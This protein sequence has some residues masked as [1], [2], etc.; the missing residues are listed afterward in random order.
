M[1][2]LLTL[3]AALFVGVLAAAVPARKGAFTV[4][5]PDGSTLRLERHGDEFFNW[6]TLAG[7]TQ[8]VRLSADG[9]WRS[10]VIDASE[11]ARGLQRRAEA[12]RLRVSARAT[13]NDNQMTHGERHIPVLLLEFTDVHFTIADPASRFNALLNQRGYSSDGATGSVQDYYWENSE[14]QFKPVFDVYGPVELPHEMKYYGETVYD[15]NGKKVSS[16]I[17]PE[18]P[19]YDGCVKLDDVIDFSRY[20]YDNDGKVDM[21]LYYYAGYNTAEGGSPDAIWPHQWHLSYSSDPDARNARFDGKQV[22]RY[23]CTSELKGSE[24]ERMCGIG[25]TCHE[26]GHSLGLPDFYDTDDEENGTCSALFDFSTMCGGSYNNDG[27]TPPWFGAEERII[28]GWMSR[29]DVRDFSEGSL[30]IGPVQDGTAYK[31]ESGVEGEYFIYECRNGEGWDAPIPKGLLV[32]HADKSKGRT[33]GGRTPYHLWNYTNN[34]NAYGDHPCFYVVPA[35]DPSNL[36]YKGKMESCVFPGTAGVRTFIPEDWDGNNLTGLILSGINYSGGLVQLSVSFDQA[37]QLIGRVTDLIGNPL[38]DVYVK[39]SAPAGSTAAPRVLR[40]EFRSIEYEAVTDE[41]GDFILALGGFEHSTGHLTLSKQGYKTAG[42]D[43]SLTERINR[44]LLSLARADQGEVRIYSY[45]DP[46]GDIYYYGDGKTNS[47]MA[48]ILIPAEELP[49]AGGTLEYVEFPPIWEADSYYII[50]DEGGNRLLT[51]PY[52]PASYDG[53]QRVDVNVPVSGKASLYVGFAVQN[54]HP[55]DDYTGYLFEITEGDGHCYLS[56][57]DL[58]TSH[59]GRGGYALVLD[60]CIIEKVAVPDPDPEPEDSFAKFGIPCI[61]DSA[62][63]VYAPGD[64]FPLMLEIPDGFTASTVQWSFD[65]RNV[66]GAK[67]VL[68][69]AGKH[70]VVARIKWADGSQETLSLQLDVK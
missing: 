2:R 34:I 65:G 50:V 16:D 56:S 3:L 43:V 49:A 18:M 66:T 61:A 25:T 60:A 42:A 15:S 6:T 10:A 23:F 40:P 21:T 11:R 48:S 64:S 5:Q 59:W 32:Y 30:S 13:H 67:S 28:L 58:T 39:L 63:G 45:Y 24:G 22:D 19:L 26:F 9:Y 44:V 1:K 37:K 20:D 31:S 69:T 14:G 41:N 33:V 12:N 68:L 54:A 38:P 47:M 51:Q 17:R 8:A 36:L 70:L 35:A 55:A 62:C 52:H 46:E 29:S 7:S 4:T 53:M 57:F 27:R